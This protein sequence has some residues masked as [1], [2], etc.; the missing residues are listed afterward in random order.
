MSKYSPETPEGSP[1]TYVSKREVLDNQYVNHSQHQLLNVTGSPVEYTLV[2]FKNLA[3][4]VI[5]YEDDHIYLV[6][7]YRYAIDQYSWELPEG[8]CPP[9]SQTLDAAKWELA[10]ET[11]LRAE[12]FEPFIHM[13]TS[14]AIT[15]EWATVYLATGLT[16]GEAEPDENEVLQTRKISLDDF[17]AEVESGKITDAMT[18]AAAYKLALMKA[19]GRL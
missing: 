15:D 19:Q 13:H 9:G 8:G 7:Q 18:V 12:K 10:E 3:V 5:P 4:G 17:L 1:W 16:Q 6:G 14:N 11:G 2:Q